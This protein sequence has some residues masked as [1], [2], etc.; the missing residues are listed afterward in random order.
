MIWEHRECLTETDEVRDL[1]EG[2]GLRVGE[3]NRQGMRWE[4][5][6][7]FSRWSEEYGEHLEMVEIQSENLKNSSER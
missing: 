2:G 3:Q 6:E 1:L 7:E 5:R 4:R